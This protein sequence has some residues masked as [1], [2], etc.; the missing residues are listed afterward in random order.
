MGPA[1][2][3]LEVAVQQHSYRLTSF[4]NGS[5]SGVPVSRI[6]CFA[7]AAAARSII[8]HLNIMD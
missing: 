4:E 2:D 8:M 7:A 6:C 1:E 5:R 3:G